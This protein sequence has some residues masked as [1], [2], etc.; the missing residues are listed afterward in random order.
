MEK[1]TMLC[2]YVIVKKEQRAC[3]DC[4]TALNVPIY[5]GIIKE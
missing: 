3:V 4:A 1:T 5:Q 2:N